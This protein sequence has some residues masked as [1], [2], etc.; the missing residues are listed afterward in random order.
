M[1]KSEFEKVLEKQRKEAKLIADKQQREDKRRLEKT[2]RLERARAIVTGK[3]MVGDMRMMDSSAEEILQII[4]SI[5]DGNEKR[6]VRG[7]IGQI[8][9][10]YD[11]V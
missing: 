6:L 4:L 2:V 3:P 7:N 5:F 9:A 1:A 10:A 11:K 8:P